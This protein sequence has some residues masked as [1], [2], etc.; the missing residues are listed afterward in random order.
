MS[1]IRP[2]LVFVLL[3][4]ASGAALHLGLPSLM[5]WHFK[6]CSAPSLACSIS[7]AFLSY[8]WLALLPVLATATLLI[9]R[10]VGRR[11]AA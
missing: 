7:A 3:Y 4:L 2:L 1:V 8:W 9:N 11:H 6:H 10:V 5:S